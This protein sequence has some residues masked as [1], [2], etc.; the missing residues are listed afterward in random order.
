M[1][2]GNKPPGSL[3]LSSRDLSLL[4]ALWQARYYTTTQLAALFWRGGPISALRAA[5][6]R[7]RKLEA[8]GLVRR[9]EPWIKRS[10]GNRP[11]LYAL[12]AQAPGLLAQTFDIEVATIDWKPKTALEHN[13]L[14]VDH[15]LAIND[16]HLAVTLSSEKHGLHVERW[17]DER[18]LKKK[19][20]RAYVELADRDGQI[21]RVAVIP[22]SYFILQTARGKG[23]FCVEMDRGTVTIDPQSGRGWAS[24]VKGYLWYHASGAYEQRYHTRHFRVLTVTT[25]STER[26]LRMKQTTEAAGGKDQFWFTT[27]DQIVHVE[28]VAVKQSTA[29]P[30]QVKYVYLPVYNQDVLTEKVWYRAGSD[31]L[32]SVLE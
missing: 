24:K 25:S 23:H 11:F 19:E 15:V 29:D 18:E 13:F 20:M 4:Y 21:T 2:S 27:A 16:F 32:H 6:R 22:D 12:G 5:Q 10:E 28:K 17:V 3:T 1:A 7:L 14:F 26:L 30:T 9:V 31:R 8:V